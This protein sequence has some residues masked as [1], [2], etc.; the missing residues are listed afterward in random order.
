MKLP[1]ADDQFCCH[2]FSSTP[3]VCLTQARFRRGSAHLNYKR[4][5]NDILLNESSFWRK[6]K[7]FSTSRPLLMDSSSNFKLEMVLLV[8]FWRGRFLVFLVFS[9]SFS[10]NLR[11]TDVDC[12]VYNDYHVRH[13]T[14]VTLKIIEITFPGSLTSNLDHF[15]N[16]LLRIRKKCWAAAKFL[17]RV[18]VIRLKLCHIRIN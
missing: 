2:K 1:R 14:R 9:G 6:R 15:V 13:Y 10:E 12:K 4:S 17:D 7:N 11:F 3:R 8:N 5:H 18:N 16:K